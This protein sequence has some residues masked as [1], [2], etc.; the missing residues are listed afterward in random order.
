M[1]S[2]S[3]GIPHGHQGD[4]TVRAQLQDAVLRLDADPKELDVL[5]RVRTYTRVLLHTGGGQIRE[6][7]RTDLKIITPTM[8]FQHSKVVKFLLTHCVA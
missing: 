6:T 3:P 5:R 7:I 8:L 2:S 1:Y 4:V